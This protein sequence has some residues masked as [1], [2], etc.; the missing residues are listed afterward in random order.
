MKIIS[1]LY[2][3]IRK[4]DYYKKQFGFSEDR[5]NILFVDP[6][7]VSFDFY[8]MIVPFLC[9]EQTG[10]FRTALTGLYRFSEIDNIHTK[11]SESEIRWADVIVLPMTLE[12]FAKPKELFDQIKAIKPDI[13]IV[14]TVEFD[15]YEITNEHY[16]LDEKEIKHFLEKTE[17]SKSKNNITEARNKMKENIIDRLESNFKGCDR[18]LVMNNNLKN[19]LIQKGCKDVKY[20]PVFIEEKS[21]KENIDFMDTLG[22]KGSKGIVFVSVDLNDETASAFR[23]YIPIFKKLRKKHGSKFRLVVIG[24]DPHKYFRKFDLEVVHLPKHSIVGQ[25]KQVVKSSADIHLVLHK[26]NVY[27]TNSQNIF[28]FVEHGLFGIPIVAPDTSPWNDVIKNRENGFLIKSKSE[29]E[30][31]VKELFKDKQKTIDLS[32]ALKDVIISRCQITDEVIDSLGGIFFYDYKV[33]EK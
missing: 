17:K 32:N 24:K 15:F 28:D 11:I 18:L 16:F 4:V 8:S 10:K 25:L 13:K 5:K 6:V 2:D 14:Q 20:V 21:F 33:K 3:N 23:Q 29:F 1:D 19:K 7:M 26:K 27:N 12:S 30:D 9:L 31:L 22:I